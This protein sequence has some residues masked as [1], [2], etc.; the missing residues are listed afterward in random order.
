VERNLGQPLSALAAGLLF[1]AGLVISGMTDPHK[2]LGF[3]DPFGA[4]DASLIFVML[5]AIA[6]HIIGQRWRVRRAT[7]IFGKNF[8]LPT[9]RDID[10]K[11]LIG[12]FIF[13]SGW[14][15]GGYCPGPGIVALGGGSVS[16]IVFVSA[17]LVGML[18]TIKVEAFL[19]RGSGEHVVPARP[20]QD[21]SARNHT[22]SA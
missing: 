7:P 8:L 9:R 12:A 20:N 19:A 17:M 10:V 22:A 15:L 4:F 18:A 5:G 3:L 14:G 1:G 6:V 11:L 16:A 13:G 2:V 21:N